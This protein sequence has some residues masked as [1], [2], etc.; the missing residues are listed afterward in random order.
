MAGETTI[1]QQVANTEA[2]VLD[3]QS[4]IAAVTAP[5]LTPVVAAVNAAAAAQ[6]TSSQALTDAVTALKASVDQ[7]VANTSVAQAGPAGGVA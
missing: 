7:L 1:E 2:A 6:A 4:K 3:I 5:D